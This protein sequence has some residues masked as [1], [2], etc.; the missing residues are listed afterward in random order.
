MLHNLTESRDFISGLRDIINTWANT[1]ITNQILPADCENVGNTK[2]IEFEFIGGGEHVTPDL[3]RSLT[4][5]SGI[6]NRWP[7]LR[8]GA[9]QLEMCPS[10]NVC[11]P[12]KMQVREGK[13]VH[14]WYRND[15]VSLSVSQKHDGTFEF[16]ELDTETNVRSQYLSCSLDDFLAGIAL[17][18]LNYLHPGARHRSGNSPEWAELIAVSDLIWSCEYSNPD[19]YTKMERVFCHHDGALLF[20]THTEY[21]GV[22]RMISGSAAFPSIEM[23]TDFLKDSQWSNNRFAVNPSPVSWMV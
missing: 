22:G 5:F 23:H 1:L 13:Y 18:S 19:S 14:F 2:R 8:I 20:E 17:W 7:H 11:N 6:V 12:R 16:T 4:V 21:P 15:S 10:R 3:P 9:S